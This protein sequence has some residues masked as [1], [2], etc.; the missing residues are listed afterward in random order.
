MK[1]LAIVVGHNS[2]SQGAVRGD[3]GESEFAWNG[4]L[5]RRIEALGAEYDLEVRVFFR[6]PGGGYKTEIHRVYDEVDRWKA[7]ASIELHFNAAGSAAAEGTETLSSGT[8]LSLRLAESVQ[9]EMV[10]A[11]GTRDRGIK[12]R[13]A[14]E[15]G[16][17]SLIAGRAPAILVEPYFGSSPLDQRATDEE[18]EQE[19]LADA[20]VRGAAEAMDSFPRADLSSSRTIRAAEVQRQAQAIQGQSGVA[21]GVAAAAT[22]AREQIAALPAVGPLADWLPWVALGLIGVV[23]VS[24]VVQRVMSDR[25]EEARVDDHERGVR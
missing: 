7:D 24:T 13:A 17:Q 11:L 10:V 1:R 18:G 9:R 23:L 14:Q 21:A 12:T 2:A 5:A 25:I 20:I 6:T 19:R 15:R 16:G 8:A 4:R 22:S 3:T